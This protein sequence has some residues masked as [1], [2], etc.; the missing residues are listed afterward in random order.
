MKRKEKSNVYVVLLAGGKGTRLWPLSTRKYSKCFIAIG[1]KKPLVA[2]TIKRLEGLAD[3]KHIIIVVDKEQARFLRK[4]AKGVPSKN[5]II[6]PFG[7]STASAIGLAA[8]EM[9]PDDVMVVLPIDALI[10]DTK[11]FKKTIEN[12]IDFAREECGSLICVGIKPR[13]ATPAYGY[14]KVKSPRAKGIY[15]V[16][17]FIEKPTRQI[18]AKFL[19]KS[20][21]LWNAGMFIFKAKS[22]LKEMET[23][24]PL[25][26]RELMRIKKNK[27]DKLKAYSRMKNV[28]I[29]YQIMEKAHNLYC[30]KGNFSW[31]DLGNWVSFGKLFKK[32]KMGNVVCGKVSL[33][34]T[35]N[36]IIYNTLEGKLAVVGL[37]DAIVVSTKN[38]TLVCSKIAAEKVKKVAS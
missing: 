2:E 33:E 5:I 18:A 22:I 31:R 35:K 23:H 27:K 21:Y 15:S 37:A 32:D 9:N 1:G 12:S 38:G 17:R 3:K 34:D 30:A 13:E 36:S 4:F 8:I 16:D 29:D 24:T 25:L 11:A 26:Y 14:I 28:S 10:E 6:E 7:R 19:K 20:G